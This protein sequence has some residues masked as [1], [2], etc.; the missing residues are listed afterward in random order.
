MLEDE[1]TVFS[2]LTQE[3]CQLVNPAVAEAAGLRFYAGA[4][5][6]MS[7]GDHIGTLC[8]IG[9]RPQL[10]TVAETELLTRLANLVSLTIE[11]R[12]CCLSKGDANAWEKVQQD[13]EGH[14]HQNSALARYLASRTEGGTLTFDEDVLQTVGRGLD[15]VEQVLEQRLAAKCA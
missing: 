9:R 13:L 15:A 1:A 12:A 3:R 6:Q 11:L 8:V 7:G 5:L 4:A 14:L 2:D 10:F